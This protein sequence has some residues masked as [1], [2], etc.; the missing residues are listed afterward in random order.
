MIRIVDSKFRT[1]DFMNG[2]RRAGNASSSVY[3]RPV[4][5]ERAQATQIN[6]HTCSGCGDQFRPK[7]SCKNSAVSAADSEPMSSANP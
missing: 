7:R 1:G 6:V 4:T 2:H 3:E 5:H